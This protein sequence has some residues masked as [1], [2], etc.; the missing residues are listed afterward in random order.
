[1]DGPAAQR[2]TAA[3]SIRSLRSL[4]TTERD[5]ANRRARRLRLPI[6]FNVQS[7]PERARKPHFFPS[8]SRENHR[9][10]KCGGLHCPRATAA[11][12]QAGIGISHILAI[13]IEPAVRV[14]TNKS[15]KR[16]VAVTLPVPSI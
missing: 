2:T 3:G 1:M 11:T 4:T 8:A 12:R 5:A 9:A 15:I 14:L 16:S 6:W 7:T 10:S 13:S